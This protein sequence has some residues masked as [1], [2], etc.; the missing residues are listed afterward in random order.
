MDTESLVE[1]RLADG[2]NLIAELAQRGFD[3]NAAF[4]IKP[5]VSGKWR[6]YIVTPLVDTEGPAKAYQ[7]V[8]PFLWTRRQPFWIDP[9][10]INLIGPSDPLAQDVLGFYRRPDGLPFYPLPWPGIYLGTTSI[11]EAYI[12]PPP[13][14]TP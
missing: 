13:A 14:T 8:H 5:S 3:V 2:Q 9:L 4:W 10:Q 1:E 6:F 11:D 12:Y 7:K